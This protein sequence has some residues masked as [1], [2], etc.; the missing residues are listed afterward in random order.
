MKSQ[1]LKFFIFFLKLEVFM[2]YIFFQLCLVAKPLQKW[3][4]FNYFGF[5]QSVNFIKLNLIFKFNK[6]IVP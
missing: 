2:F 3:L 1:H 5:K 4:Y 6:L